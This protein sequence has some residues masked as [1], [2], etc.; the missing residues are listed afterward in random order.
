MFSCHW[1]MLEILR[2]PF[3]HF[4]LWVSKRSE[5]KSTHNIWHWQYNY[6]CWYNHCRTPWLC[7]S[8]TCDKFPQVTPPLLPIK[9]QK[10]KSAK[11]AIHPILSTK[12][13]PIFTLS[14]PPI[15]YKYSRLAL[16]LSQHIKMKQRCSS[17]DVWKRVRTHTH[18]H[19]LSLSLRKSMFVN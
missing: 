8:K 15:S 19:T 10:E 11:K 18:T 14:S 2:L 13:P 12:Q 5:D 17:N 6:I 3:F 9:K 7:I 1:M 4:L 16:P